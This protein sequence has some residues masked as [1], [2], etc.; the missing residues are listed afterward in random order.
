MAFL[1]VV[2][3]GGADIRFNNHVPKDCI[4]SLELRDV[5]LKY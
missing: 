2:V 1:R 5:W 4:L 3:G